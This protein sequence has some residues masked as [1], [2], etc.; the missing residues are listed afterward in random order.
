M[1][2]SFVYHLMFNVWSRLIFFPFQLAGRCNRPRKPVDR[3]ILLVFWGVRFVL[4]FM[5]KKMMIVCVWFL[6][7]V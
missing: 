4:V 2:N 5:L 1:F 7:F 3:Y 6:V